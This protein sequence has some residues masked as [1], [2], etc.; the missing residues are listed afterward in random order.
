MRGSIDAAGDI[1]RRYRKIALWVIA[2]GMLLSLLVMQITRDTSWLNALVVT[3]VYSFLVS[4][5]YGLAWEHVARTSPDTLAKFYLAGS[6]LRLIAAAMVFLVYAV[7]VRN[8]PEV[9]AFAVLFAAFYV[10]L[11][12]FDCVFFA[13]IEKSKNK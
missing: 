10:V 11:L 5:V 8:K 2:G 13:R 3:V 4:V 9:L 7:I 12:L 1:G 6:A